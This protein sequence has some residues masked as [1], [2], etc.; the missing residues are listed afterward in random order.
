MVHRVL[1]TPVFE[2]TAEN[3]NCHSKSKLYFHQWIPLNYFLDQSELHKNIS[4]ITTKCLESSK[5]YNEMQTIF[6]C[7]SID[8]I[9]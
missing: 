1:N 2:S 5:L 6:S 9:F 3:Y 4:I 7:W 8:M